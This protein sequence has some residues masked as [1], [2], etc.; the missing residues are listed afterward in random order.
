MIWLILDAIIILTVKNILLTK[1]NAKI[2]VEGI[3]LKRK[4]GTYGTADWGTKEEI[5]EYLGIGKRNGIIIGET[6]EK[7]L[8]TLPL[9]TYLNKNIAVFRFEWK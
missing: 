7:E 4:D 1:E 8:I 9:D 6:E 3:R 2:E 5:E